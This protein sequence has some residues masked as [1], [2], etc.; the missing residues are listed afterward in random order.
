LKENLMAY[1]FLTF[2]LGILSIFLLLWALEMACTLSDATAESGFKCLPTAEDEMGPLYKPGAPVRQS[3]GSGYL[4][5]GE[6]KSA[7]DCQPVSGAKIEIWMAGP[8]GLYGDNWRATL[9][10]SDKGTYHFTS[11]VPP[12]YGTGR[13]HIHIK[14]TTDNYKEL[15]TQHYPKSD[16]GMAVFDLVLIPEGP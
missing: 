2:C 11:H 8:G 13:P 6:V 9:F 7:A 5:M 14:V 3:V 4:L 15:V 1:R 12:N 16:A 10:S